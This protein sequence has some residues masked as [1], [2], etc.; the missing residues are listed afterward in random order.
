MS[1]PPVVESLTADHRLAYTYKRS[2]GPV[3]GR[4]F[5]ALRD[6]RILGVRRRDGTVM[7]PPKE[8]DPDTGEALEEL[9]PVGSAGVVVSWAWVPEPRPQQPLEHP[10]AFALVRLDG[11]DTP[12]LH[13]VDAGEPARMATGMR[14]RA[15]WAGKTVGHIRDIACFEPEDAP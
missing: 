4:F 7:V 3:L 8:Y 5:T 11:A 13:A 1:H 9:V 12:L 15:R 2:V 10:F 14:V 6:R